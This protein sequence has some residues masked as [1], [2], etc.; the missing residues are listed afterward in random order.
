MDEQ[1][2][3]LETTLQEK[4]YRLT[5]ARRTILEA[6]V[7]SGGHVSADGL[8]ATIN[9]S[10][11]QVGRMTV[12]RTLDLLQQLGLVRPI[13][14]GS[15]AAQ[16]VLMEEGH[17]HH[18]LCSSCAAVI[19]F[20]ECVVKEVEAAIRDRFHFEIQGHLLEFYGLCPECRE[21]A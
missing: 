5:G 3:R 4:G 17:H 15:G 16:Y 19:E 6:L 10:A 14:P 11:A 9:R 20:D 13:N 8:A 12:Y 7:E 21:E 1:I 2:E 18:L